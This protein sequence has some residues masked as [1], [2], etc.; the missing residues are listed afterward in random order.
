[1]T[2]KEITDALWNREEAGLA[3]VMALCGARCRRIAG[4][5]LPEMY[6]C[7]I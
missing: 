6:T 1:M 5:I 3:A 2:D 4:N 7:W